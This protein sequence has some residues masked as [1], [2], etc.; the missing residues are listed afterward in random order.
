MHRAAVPL[1]ALFALVLSPLAA[2]VVA[3][4][5]E[6]LSPPIVV[7][8]DPAAARAFLDRKDHDTLR[9]AD[10]ELFD[11]TFRAANELSDLED[12]LKAHKDPKTLREA[13]G[14]RGEHELLGTPRALEVWA[15]RRMPG[16][17][18]DTVRAGVYEWSS[19]DDF[20]RGALARSGQGEKDWAAL[21]FAA[22]RD[23]VAKV[24]A[25]GFAAIKGRVPRTQAELTALEAQKEALSPWLSS[26]QTSEADEAVEHAQALLKGLADA[27]GP[28]ASRGDPRL[29]ALLAEARAAP[30]TEAAL[31]KLAQVFDGLGMRNPAVADAGP[32]RPDQR[33]EDRSR[34][35]L[36]EMLRSGVMR[37]M[38]GTVVG[39]DLLRFYEKNDMLLVVKPLAVGTLGEFD[40]AKNELSVNEAEVEQWLRRENRTVDSLLKGGPGFNDLLRAV[41]SVVVHEAIHHQQNIWQK[42]GGLPDI[43]AQA[44]EIEAKARESA[45]VLEKSA[46]DKAYRNFMQNNQKRFSFVKT[47]VSQ[48]AMLARDP[49]AF[50]AEVMTDYYPNNASIEADTAAAARGEADARAAAPVVYA[51]F[52]KRDREMWDQVTDVLRRVR[53]NPQGQPKGPPAP[54]GVR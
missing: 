14:V 22:R 37:E 38:K 15:L 41:L 9:D 34:S 54:A 25:E 53:R 31:A 40:S 1:T 30:D 48:S 29:A 18:R 43:G 46:K 17:S 21:P 47:A 4:S 20:L 26:D 2:Q 39:D 11:K 19:L 28:V 5:L 45:F 13:L 50:R 49:A 10:E 7:E 42:D 52:R 44:S 12:V 33:F 23:A 32:G 6:A 27:K 3:P 8:K 36:S 51:A 35:Q 16:V 24:A